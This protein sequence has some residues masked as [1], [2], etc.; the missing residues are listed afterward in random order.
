MNCSVD[1]GSIDLVRWARSAAFQG[2]RWQEISWMTR[3]F[4][5][6]LMIV[7]AA[8]SLIAQP[9]RA[10]TDEPGFEGEEPGRMRPKTGKKVRGDTA[11]ARLSQ[12]K[13][14]KLFQ[15]FSKA[16]QWELKTNREQTE[17]IREIMKKF[18]AEVEGSDGPKKKKGQKELTEAEDKQA[19]KEVARILE[20]QDEAQKLIL[21]GERDRARE[22]LK[23]LPRRERGFHKNSTDEL[24]DPR[25]FY[26]IDEVLAEPIRTQFWKIVTRFTTKAR[27]NPGA[28]YLDLL[29]D[30]DLSREQGA[31][32]SLHY[33]S[34]MEEI[35]KTNKDDREAL[36]AVQ[37]TFQ[38][39][40]LAEL[41]EEQRKVFRLTMTEFER[42]DK[43]RKQKS[44]G[45]ARW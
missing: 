8:G 11:V 32:I 21:R 16:M 43:Q 45:S 14:D 3:A 38:R 28:L 35:R 18:R 25:M 23:Q 22:L 41:S 15:D 42:H 2:E 39:D 9:V 24:L 40:L 10:Q 7:A 1:S 17:Q 36:R 19:A 12:S 4:L 33:K 30:I 44:E 27:V 31:A 5:Y 20:I 13:T 6:G 37:G 26:A 34:Y 29:R